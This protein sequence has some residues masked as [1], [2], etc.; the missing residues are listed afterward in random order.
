MVTPQL[1][2][3]SIELLALEAF[4]QGGSLEKV[5]LE[6]RDELQR[7]QAMPRPVAS[8]RCPVA[9]ETAP[10]LLNADSAELA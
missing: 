7:L 5:F 10:N 2:R 1:H 3:G 9:G 8:A 6:L 4:E